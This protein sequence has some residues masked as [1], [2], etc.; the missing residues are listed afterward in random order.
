MSEVIRLTSIPKSI[1]PLY[2]LC[3]SCGGSGERRGHPV[4]VSTK[5]GKEVR[6]P[7]PAPQFQRKRDC[8]ACG[9]IG[10]VLS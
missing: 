6:D 10:E 5:T 8:P 3:K 7:N 9:G 1:G 2:R 4:G